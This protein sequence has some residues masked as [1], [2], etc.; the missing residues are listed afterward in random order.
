MVPELRRRHRLIWQ[1]GALVLILGFCG[2][3]WVLPKPGFSASLVQQPHV[4]FPQV[5]TTKKV[6]EFSF[7]LRGNLQGEKQLEVTIQKPL[8]IPSAQIYWQNNFIGSLGSKGVQ[9]FL[10]PK[11]L[12]QKG[13]HVLEMRSALD[14]SAFQKI[15][16][17][18]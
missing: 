14:Q 9:L 5:L 13:D 1:I 12:V 3:V 11:E 2:A 10:L 16:F 17:T 15:T 6:D 4:V 18:L 7:V 8:T